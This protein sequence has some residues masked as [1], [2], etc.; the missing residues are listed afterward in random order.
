[1]VSY[2]DKDTICS[3]KRRSIRLSRVRVMNKLHVKCIKCGKEWE[4]DSVIPWHSDHF[5]SSLC[6]SCFIE[7]AA[8]TIHRKQLNEGNFDCFATASAYCD[9]LGCKYRQ[10]CLHLEE[11]KQ[12]ERDK[13][14]PDR[15]ST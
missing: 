15:I 9:Q 13:A 7:V 8:P 12:A 1:M 2:H 4:K 5:S 14:S 3:E 10:W 11:L 6:N